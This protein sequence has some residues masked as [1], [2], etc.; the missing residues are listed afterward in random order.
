MDPNPSQTTE[1]LE[2]AFPAITHPKKVAFL[3]AF[4]KTGNVGHAAEVAEI[5]RKTHFNWR[6]DDPDYAAAFKLAQEDAADSLEKEARRRAEEGVRKLV[7]YK[8]ELVRVPADPT[9][10]F[11]ATSNPLVPLVEHEYSDTLAIFL[12]KALRPAKFR[13]THR[14][15]H[16]GA[17]GGPIKSETKVGPL[18]LTKLT[19]TDLETLRE[20]RA[21]AQP[22]PGVN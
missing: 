20:L 10:P 7:T 6:H 4:R 17:N 1:R 12:L 8:G 9:K 18:D 22:V 3:S 2:R 16:T 15:E 5:C 11:D 13:E 19:D 21:K 14:H